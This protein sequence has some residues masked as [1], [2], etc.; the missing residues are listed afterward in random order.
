ME[1]QYVKPVAYKFLSKDKFENNIKYRP[2]K[3]YNNKTAY[4][5]N[6]VF[7]IYRFDFCGNKTFDLSE[8]PNE[9]NS[10][11]IYRKEYCQKGI[12]IVEGEKNADDGHK[13]NLNVVSYLQP[14]L[15]FDNL[16]KSF[17]SFSV[18]GAIIIEDNDEVGK[19][20]SQIILR[21][22]WALSIP[23]KAVNLSEIYG[24]DKRGFDLS[25]ALGL[26]LFNIEDIL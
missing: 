9:P 21:S 2:P 10:N 7:S 20:K 12:I 26:E 3:K 23:A 1:D 16:C 8:V 5:Y 22:M 13:L 6:D 17:K 25:D 4:N 14:K 11:F 19:K 18:E 24:V 15:S